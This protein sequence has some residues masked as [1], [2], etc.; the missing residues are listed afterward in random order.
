[1]TPHRCLLACLLAVG[2]AAVAGPCAAQLAPARLYYGIDR[3]MP[4]TVTVPAG[5]AGDVTIE[6][7]APGAQAAPEQPP[8]AVAPTVAGAIDLATHFPIL[9]SQP[10]PRLFYAQLSIGGQRIGPP[11]VLEPLLSPNTATLVD[12]ATLAPA[13]DPASGTLIFED[14]RLTALRS[15]DP[16]GATPAPRLV[17]YAG[18]RAYVDKHIVLDTTLGEIEFRLRPDQAPNTAWNFRHL[19]EGG[20]YTDVIFHRVVATSQVGAPFV[21]QA[22]DPTGSGEGGPGYSIDLEPSALP[23]DFGVLS[24]ARDTDP[25][26]NG[27]Q[28]FVALSRE[29]TARLDGR[30]TA[31]GQ[32]V[33]GADAIVAIEQVEQLP[34]P[35]P[36]PGKPAP[37]PKNRPKDPPV[38]RSARLVDAP[39]YGKSP[40]P[41]VRPS[42][43]VP[44]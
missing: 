42:P 43:P 34:E 36:E 24:M 40:L 31:F 14:A 16:S 32:A 21:I 26:T 9:W 44:R 15:R 10:A 22:G 38:I 39:P 6:L 2:I 30:Y 3:S 4:M 5:A 33:R 20:F 19:A 37:F 13:P 28:F 23:H 11:V 29:A 1:M 17:T 41:A 12:P 35:A 25:N 7:H 18:I 27:S 8:V